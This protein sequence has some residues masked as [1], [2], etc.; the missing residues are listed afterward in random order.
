MQANLKWIQTVQKQSFPAEI[1]NI[2]SQS[3]HLPLVRQLRLFI[4][5]GAPICCGGR[6]HNAPV[7][8]ISL[9]VTSQTPI[10]QNHCLCNPLHAGVNSTMTAIRQSYWIPSA[11]QWIRK[12]LRHCVTCRKTEGKSYQMPDPPPPVKCRVQET[13]PFEVT[14]VDFTGAE[15]QAKRVC[16]FTCTVTRAMHLEIITNLT[17]KNF[18]QAFRRF[19]SCKSLPKVMLSDNASTYWWTQWTV[20][21]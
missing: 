11:R 17:T 4:D 1:Q 3:S 21:L 15:T 5:K 20:Q 13:Q 18:L 14:G 8:E 2:N 10:Y 12:L 7:S 6:I 19:S 16:F 9:P